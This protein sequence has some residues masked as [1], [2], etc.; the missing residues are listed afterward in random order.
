M[1]HLWMI[2]PLKMVIFHS[3]LHVYQRV[4]CCPFICGDFKGR[5]RYCTADRPSKFSRSDPGA[6]RHCRT[7]WTL[8]L[9]AHWGCSHF[10]Q[11]VGVHCIAVVTAPYFET[12]SNIANCVFY[13]FLTISWHRWK[14]S[15][16]NSFFTTCSSRAARVAQCKY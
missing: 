11:H 1:A 16:G 10:S 15:T 3:F 12:K 9:G 5:S 6:L 7:V 8:V 4:D 2:F 14:P 13:S